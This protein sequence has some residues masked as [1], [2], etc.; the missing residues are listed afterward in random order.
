MFC[1]HVFGNI[2]GGF[3]GISR[4]FGNFAGFRGNTL[5]SRVCNR[6][7]YQKPCHWGTYMHMHSTDCCYIHYCYV[8][9]DTATTNIVSLGECYSFWIQQCCTTLCPSRNE[10]KCWEL[11]ACTCNTQQCCTCLHGVLILNPQ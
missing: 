8:Q 10:R 4:F 5:I 7:K 1:R 6:A 9:T 11:W 2:S 3:H